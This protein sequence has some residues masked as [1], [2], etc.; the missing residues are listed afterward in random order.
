MIIVF[1]LTRVAILS[2][3]QSLVRGLDGITILP[4]YLHDL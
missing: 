1:I 2:T 3:N 4:A